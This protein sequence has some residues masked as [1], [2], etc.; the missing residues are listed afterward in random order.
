M[1]ESSVAGPVGPSR[2]RVR[3]SGMRG[4]LGMSAN[5]AIHKIGEFRDPSEG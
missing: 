4:Y 3:G 2:L 1:E 5:V